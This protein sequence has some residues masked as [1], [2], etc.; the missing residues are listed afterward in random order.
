M[1]QEVPPAGLG[2]P[3]APGE[4]RECCSAAAGCAACRGPAP[5]SCRGRFSKCGV[6]QGVKDKCV[7]ASLVIQKPKSG[8]SPRKL[9]GR[10]QQ[11]QDQTVRRRATAGK[12]VAARLIISKG[13]IRVLP[14]ET[15]P[16][17]E[18]DLDC[19]LPTAH[20]RWGSSA[21]RGGWAAGRLGAFRC[22]ELMS[23]F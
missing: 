21:K 18:G 16:G 1:Q 9:Q 20:A 8:S 14:Q 6:R 23:H 5:G 13:K 12:C 15:A 10:V 19:H 17:R 7:A 22:L 3:P 2:S 4:R 11:A